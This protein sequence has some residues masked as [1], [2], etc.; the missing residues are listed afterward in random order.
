MGVGGH[1]E[2][3]IVDIVCE[4]N[5]IKLS[6]IQQKIIEDHVNFEGIN[7]VSLSTVDR[8]LKRNRLRM[9]QLYRVPFDRNSDRVKE[10]RFQYVQQDNFPVLLQ[11]PAPIYGARSMVFFESSEEEFANNIRSLPSFICK[12]EIDERSLL[13]SGS[14]DFDH[15]YD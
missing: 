10:Q 14:P 9:K 15:F 7:S 6:E 4:N 12:G 13:W 2:T 1:Q 3:L 11:R 5:A 8:V